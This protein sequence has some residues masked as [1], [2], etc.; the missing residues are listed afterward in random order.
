MFLR[1]NLTIAKNQFGSLL[2][3]IHLGSLESSILKAPASVIKFLENIPKF[4]VQHIARGAIQQKITYLSPAK[5]VISCE[6]GLY[7]TVV[8]VLT[9]CPHVLHVHIFL[10]L[11]VTSTEL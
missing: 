11:A 1:V 4:R 6:A 3:G 10:A 5:P 2:S 8:T 9:V 7:I